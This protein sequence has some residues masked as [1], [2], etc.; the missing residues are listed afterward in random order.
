MVAKHVILVVVSEPEQRVRF[1]RFFKRAGHRL[2]YALSEAEALERFSEAK[3]D[4]VLADA[5][6][7]AQDGSLFRS[8]RDTEGGAALPLVWFGPPGTE[9]GPVADAVVEY[10]PDH[11]EARSIVALLLVFGREAAPQQ[12]YR[13]PVDR[14]SRRAL[15]DRPKP[16]VGDDKPRSRGAEDRAAGRAVEDPPFRRPPSPARGREPTPVETAAEPVV[17]TLDTETVA[18]AK[19][20]FFR[21][22][23]PLEDEPL[24]DPLA[25]SLDLEELP[26]EVAVATDELEGVAETEDPSTPSEASG[27]DA[28]TKLRASLVS[29]DGASSPAVPS[30]EGSSR[31]DLP[32]RRAP[33]SPPPPRGS[34][35]GSSSEEGRIGRR[36]L[37]E[38]QLGKRLIQRI[39]TLYAALD[40]ADH[41]Q[42]LG[43][44]PGVDDARVH[45]A[46][47]DLSLELHPDRFFLLRS[48]ELKE[49]IYAIYR[50]A[51]EAHQVLGDPER[52]A[53][54]DRLRNSGGGPPAL[55]PKAAAVAATLDEPSSGRLEV[56]TDVPVARAFVVR[57]EDAFERGAYQEARF[58]LHAVLALE[59]DNSS[60]QRA[61]SLV[62]GR[63]RPLI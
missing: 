47:F 45:S 7:K 29:P 42:L 57:A 46:W 15:A 16:R 39:R 36:G 25:V 5:Q 33:A 38:S 54:Y 43:I 19:N 20:P 22:E 32:R 35:D 34:V 52:R 49:K 44:S 11:A 60:A 63:L 24:D 50:R 58:H 27:P 51:A 37:D 31:R 53:E 61:L 40:S 23:I 21:P 28:R 26:V 56:V 6:L 8:L 41:Y 18:G 55:V 14:R 59:S 4:L 10:P 30:R 12:P 9:R 1:N 2:V 62:E 48:G 3:P 13:Q 17:S